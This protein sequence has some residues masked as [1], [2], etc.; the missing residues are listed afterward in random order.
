MTHIS[1]TLPH[2]STL[3]VPPFH[4]FHFGPPRNLDKLSLLSAYNIII[5]IIIVLLSD[6][7][8]ESLSDYIPHVNQV[9]SPGCHQYG[10]V[11]VQNQAS[12]F[13]QMRVHFET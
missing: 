7:E 9:V 5:Y 2:L 11:V 8:K 1:C 13:S 4:P 6:F 3:S 10:L 12:D